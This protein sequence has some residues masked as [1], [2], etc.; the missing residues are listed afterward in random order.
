M[1]WKPTFHKRSKKLAGIVVGAVIA[2]GGWYW[3][4]AAAQS[5]QQD[6]ARPVPISRG[7]IEELV[8][9]QGKH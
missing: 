7:T 9:T 2:A 8:T 4:S 6:A 1:N 5:R 3:Y